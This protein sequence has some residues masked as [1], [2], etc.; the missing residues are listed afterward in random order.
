MQ[1]ID[2]MLKPVSRLKLS[3]CSP[4]A[5]FAPEVP[6][7]GPSEAVVTQHCVLVPTQNMECH[8][9][10]GWFLS[11]T[12][13]SCA[14]KK[15]ERF[16]PNFPHDQRTIKNRPESEHLP[17]GEVAPSTLTMGLPNWGLEIN[18][19]PTVITICFLTSL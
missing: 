1:C 7:R 6:P 18:V 8:F 17:R 19:R 16:D 12:C 9:S 15:H 3:C 4:G 10:T 14:R 5:L 2:F 11:K 13:S